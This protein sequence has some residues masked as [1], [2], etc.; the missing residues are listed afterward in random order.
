MQELDTPLRLTWSIGGSRSP[1]APLHLESLALKVAE[2][3]VLFPTLV[4]D[5]LD[6]PGIEA[7]LASL[8]SRGAQITL[9][10]TD[11]DRLTRAL[12]IHQ[13]ALDANGL[14]EGGERRF[15]GALEAARGLGYEPFVWFVPLKSYLSDIPW[16]F[17]MCS[18]S[19]VGRIK[20]SNLPINAS[21]GPI[22]TA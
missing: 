20:L 14:R 10:T 21:Y 9:V 22:E 13:L 15:D 19:G 1:L 11:V 5:P 8:A 12:P 7:A 4:D 18:A 2:A 6:H 16:L 17:R 3:G